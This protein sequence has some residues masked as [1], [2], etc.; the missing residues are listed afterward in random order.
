M[1]AN[2]SSIMIKSNTSSGTSF[3]LTDLLSRSMITAIDA[4]KE[5]ALKQKNVL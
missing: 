2:R 5:I 3:F 1:R 4:M